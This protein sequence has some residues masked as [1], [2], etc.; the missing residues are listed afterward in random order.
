MCWVSATLP[1]LFSVN[2]RVLA[3]TRRADDVAPAGHSSPSPIVL[4]VKLH[5]FDRVLCLVNE[6]KAIA[7]IGLNLDFAHGGF[8]VVLSHVPAKPEAPAMG[9]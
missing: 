8:S 3:F 9:V 2:S 5:I 7:L 6:G 4:A 1:F